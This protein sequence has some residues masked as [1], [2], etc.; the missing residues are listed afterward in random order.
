MNKLF[1]RMV[2][3]V[4]MVCLLSALMVPVA[5]AAEAAD[6]YVIDFEIDTNENLTWKPFEDKDAYTFA[7]TNFAHAQI[8]NGHAVWLEA[9]TAYYENGDINFS[10]PHTVITAADAE[11]DE[12]LAE[13]VGKIADAGT[14]KSHFK[15]TNQFG[16]YKYNNTASTIDWTGLKIG[17]AS[18]TYNTSGTG[19]NAMIL[20][21]PDAG[22]YTVSMEYTKYGAASN[23]TKVF[24]LP[25]TAEMKA[26]VASDPAGWHADIEALVAEGD[27]AEEYLGKFSSW[28]AA[29][30]TP[31]PGNVADLGEVTIGL[32]KEY[33]MVLAEPAG[34]YAYLQNITFTPVAEEEIAAEVIERNYSI[35]GAV[36]STVTLQNT[37]FTVN[38]DG[39]ATVEAL[40][41]AGTIDWSWI[42]TNSK[43]AQGTGVEL[44]K[45]YIYNQTVLANVTGT[46]NDTHAYEAYKLRSPGAGKYDISFVT[47]VPAAGK[48]TAW[49][50]VY[51]AEYTE[52]MDPLSIVTEE[53][54]VGAHTPKS[55]ANPVAYKNATTAV[56][57]FEFAEGK[58]YILVHK[59]DGNKYGW[60]TNSA[61]TAN[62]RH[63]T[64][65]FYMVAFVIEA[66]E[67]A[68]TFVPKA[69][70]GTTPY[71]TV[72]A[73][74]AAAQSGDTVKLAVDFLGNIDLP[75]GVA[76]DLAGHTWT[77]SNA[78]TTNALEYITD[79]V[80]GGKL[81]T[82]SMDLYGDNNG[83]LP[84][85]DN[86]A[87][88]LADYTLGVTANDYEVVN[89]AT[90][91][92][93]KLSLDDAAAYDL[94]ASGNS[95]LTIGVKL[96]WGGAEDLV[97]TF[98]NGNG[99]ETFAA[100]WA[101]AAKNNANIWLYVDIV[102]VDALANDLTVTP[103]LNVSD[104]ALNAGSL[105]Y[106]VA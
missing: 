67:E 27:A 50:D 72:A 37:D 69:Y 54:F 14:Y 8:D 88:T 23:G 94:I 39:V 62:D 28:I 103:V 30:S 26:K 35:A 55:S 17:A 36:N 76:L 61:D 13:S 19:W 53:N 89:E 99:A 51:I 100:E 40:Y 42:G 64:A 84:L 85:L 20:R 57:E 93:F 105:V 1:K 3:C 46:D 96:S 32:E 24:L 77:V 91:F 18:S 7:G 5:T 38:T 92:W 87:Y 29:G 43:D 78:T 82:N 21:A 75:A 6:P 68:P 86:G 101:A 83:K 74:A 12:S 11:A 65:N 79:S 33:L 80:G 15:N 25:Y 98:D 71:A 10:F 60:P 63:Y 41:D 90:R 58:E 16:S 22:N 45:G 97:V 66:Q 73:A 70:I 104:S 52:G 49:S 59:A 4:L 2:V 44:Q 102:G 106:D 31:V 47:Y 81:A 9:F 56:G 34:K 48:T 95:G